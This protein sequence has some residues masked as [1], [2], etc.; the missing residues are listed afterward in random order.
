MRTDLRIF[1][2]VV[3]LQSK[4]SFKSSCTCWQQKFRHLNQLLCI[5]FP[6]LRNNPCL[7]QC[8]Y[9]LDEGFY[10]IS[11]INS[12]VKVNRRAWCNY[13]VSKCSMFMSVRDQT[14]ENRNSAFTVNLIRILI[15]CRFTWNMAEGDN[16]G[17]KTYFLISLEGILYLLQFV[18]EILRLLCL[19]C[20]RLLILTDY[21]RSLM[22][23]KRVRIL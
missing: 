8:F 16:Y 2:W 15:L 11:S 18:S 20:K 3:T 23:F 13:R 6:F 17:C 9:N 14:F 1:V 10:R 21:F 22:E 7:N 4:A 5:F 19:S 12:R